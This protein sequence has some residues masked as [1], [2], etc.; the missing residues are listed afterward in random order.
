LDGD[1]G[2][3]SVEMPHCSIKKEEEIETDEDLTSFSDPDLQH[4]HFA[5]KKDKKLVTDRDIDDQKNSPIKKGRRSR[6]R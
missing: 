4:Y 3:P 1:E 5:G 6:N 2:H